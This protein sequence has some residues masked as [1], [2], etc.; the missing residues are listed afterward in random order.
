MASAIEALVSLDD[1]ES[2]F[3]RGLSEPTLQ[4]WN[5]IRVGGLRATDTLRTA[6][7]R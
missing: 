4:N 5:G 3:M 1:A 7:A 6:L 2:A